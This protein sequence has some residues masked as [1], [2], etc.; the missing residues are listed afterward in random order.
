MTLDVQGGRST[1]YAGDPGAPDLVALYLRVAE[2]LE[3][4]AELAEQHAERCRRK[5]ERE[6]AATELACAK[7]AHTTAQRGRAMA[8]QLQAQARPED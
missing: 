3:R 1:G 8:L 2:T 6:S 4:S 7:R 5:G